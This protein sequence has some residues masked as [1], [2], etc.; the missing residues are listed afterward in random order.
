MI[1]CNG[2]AS[3]G[4]ASRGRIK[5]QKQKQQIIKRQKDRKTIEEVEDFMEVMR[6]I[7]PGYYG[8]G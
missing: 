1:T 6:V 3:G 5:D 7:C 4:S 8:G 2:I